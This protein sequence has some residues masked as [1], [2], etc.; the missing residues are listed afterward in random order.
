MAC[1]FMKSVADDVRRKTGRSLRFVAP[2]WLLLWFAPYGAALADPPAWSTAFAMYGDIKY[3]ANFAHYDF[4][5]PDAPKG[6]VLTLSNPD[7]YTSFDKF[8]P[9]T[10]RGQAPRGL[11]LLTFETLTDA[12]MDEPATMYGLIA[13][14]MQVA[15]DYSWVAFHVDPAA[16][17]SNGDP[18]TADDVK[19]SYDMLTGPNAS[20]D[21]SGIFEGVKS[22]TVLDPR[23]IRFDLKAPSNDQIFQLGTNLFVFS[24]KWGAGPDGKPKSF[25]QIVN[26]LPI[27]SGPYLVGRAESGSFLELNRDPNYWAKDKGVRR[28]F[29][30][31]DHIIYHYF[32]DNAARFEAFKAGDFDLIKEYGAKRWAKQYVGRKF[33]DGRIQKTSLPDGMGFTLE[34]ML[35]NTRRPLFQDIR[36][37]EALNYSFN[38][39][40]TKLQSYSLLSRFDG[41]FQNSPFAA[42]GSPSSAELAL[43]EP[44]RAQLPASVFG[45]IFQNPRTDTGPYALRQNLL[46]ARDL[47]AQA[48][49]LLAPDGRLRNASGQSFDFEFLSDELTWVTTIDPWKQNLEKLGISLTYRVVD[50]AI[51][52]KRLQSFDYDVIV[53]NYPSFSV[54]SVTSMQSLFA[55]KNADVPASDNLMGIKNPAMDHVLDAMNEAKTIPELETASHA[56]D[57]IFVSE[58]Y[59]IP[60]NYRAFLDIAYANRFGMPKV[61][62][63]YFSIDEGYGAA[64]WPVYT[65]WDKS[66]QASH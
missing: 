15:P 41:L 35:L 51:Y 63:R 10:I 20:P 8:N 2:F 23:T 53:I 38:W 40:W 49:W 31:F 3:P 52:F 6:G 22:A 47:L 42:T 37:R 45:P 1:F 59:A 62:P 26:D 27:A 58:H 34:G 44:Y 66:L 16:H 18:V 24:K 5:N 50:P 12:S 25:D 55:S 65:W 46:H 19:Y 11:V 43:L 64:P 7:R 61:L 13:S 17:F 54:P 60:M 57:R 48:G 56:L 9:F 29:F 30:N 21:Y 39:E 4:V 33:D 28:G 32:A 36:V 14:E